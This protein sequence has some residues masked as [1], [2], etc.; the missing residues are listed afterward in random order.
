MMTVF[1]SAGRITKR[2]SA[3][4]VFGFVRPLLEVLLADDEPREQLAVGR[5]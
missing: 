3:V 1:G 5:H 2:P 4:A